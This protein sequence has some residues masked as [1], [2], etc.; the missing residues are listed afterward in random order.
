MII[1]DETKSQNNIEYELS[2][3]SESQNYIVYVIIGILLSYY[4]ISIQK[5]QLICSYTGTDCSYLPNQLLIQLTGNILILIA[6][7]FFFNLSAVNLETPTDNSKLQSSNELNYV[8]SLLVVIA[9]VIRFYDLTTKYTQSD[10][11]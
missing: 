7:F 10:F 11:L 3:L 5:E 4:S 6:V 8:A 2:I 9:T 1:I